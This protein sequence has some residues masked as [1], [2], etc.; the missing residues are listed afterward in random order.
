MVVN[1]M[2][3]T[4]MRDPEKAKSYL[5]ANGADVGRAV[6]RYWD[7]FDKGGVIGGNGSSMDGGGEPMDIDEE[8][9]EQAFAEASKKGGKKD[10]EAYM[11]DAWTVWDDVK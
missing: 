10:E 4:G 7:E 5:S 1:F 9:D 6:G 8:H 2:D 3:N 11:F